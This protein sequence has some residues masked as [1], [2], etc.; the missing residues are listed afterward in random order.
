[1]KYRFNHAIA[2]YKHAKEGEIKMLKGND[3][4]ILSDIEVRLLYDALRIE[5]NKA[6]YKKLQELGILDVVQKMEEFLFE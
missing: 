4:I 2:G 3:F 6:T 1:M 5:K